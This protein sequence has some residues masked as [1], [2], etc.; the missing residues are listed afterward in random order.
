M[1]VST[2]VVSTAVV[3]EQVMDS[4]KKGSYLSLYNDKTLPGLN[5]FSSSNQFRISSHFSIVRHGKWVY[6]FC[7]I[8]STSLSGFFSSSVVVNM[9]PL[10]TA[11]T[12]S[13]WSAVDCRHLADRY[14]AFNVGRINVCVLISRLKCG[15]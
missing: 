10:V 5:H 15:L 14:P 8:S 1:Y 6:G 2:A 11:R 13:S 4:K 7:S 9:L 12:H 3:N